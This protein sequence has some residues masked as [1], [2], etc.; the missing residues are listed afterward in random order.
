MRGFEK[1]S[2]PC[3]IL[4]LG[5]AWTQANRALS[6][7]VPHAPRMQF[8]PSETADSRSELAATASVRTHCATP[9]RGHKFSP[10]ETGV[11]EHGLLEVEFSASRLPAPLLTAAARETTL[12]PVLA[13]H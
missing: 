13:A 11:G 1:G 8:S 6:P 12:A 3:G 5:L 4:H 7:P 10:S 2:E 9:V